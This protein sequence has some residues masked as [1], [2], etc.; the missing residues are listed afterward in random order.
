[1]N[2]FEYARIYLFWFL[3]ETYFRSQRGELCSDDGYL[4][5]NDIE[6]C[7]AATLTLNSNSNY[8]FENAVNFDNLPKGCYLFQYQTVYF[9]HHSTGSKNDRANQI[10]KPG[11]NG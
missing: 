9:N 7:K 11:G 8:K 10:C 4:A 1:M 6:T 3:G 2:I 5:V